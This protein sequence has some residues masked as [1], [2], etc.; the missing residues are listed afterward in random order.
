MALVV[1]EE[2]EMEAK[3]IVDASGH[4]EVLGLTP[5]RVTVEDVRA[6]FEQ[7]RRRLLTR[8]SIRSPAVQRARGLLEKAHQALSDTLLLDRALS[9]SQRQ[10]EAKYMDAGQM[11]AVRQRTRDLE[12]QAERSRRAMMTA[13]N[14]P[15]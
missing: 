12:A 8:D 1:S 3:R 6:A 15:T 5:P 4:F 2:W 11:E 13:A 10:K 14:V 9:A 7:S